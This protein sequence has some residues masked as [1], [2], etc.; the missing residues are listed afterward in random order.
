MAR[1]KADAAAGGAAERRAEDVEEGLVRAA[2]FCGR[3]P[4]AY[5]RRG[6]PAAYALL[7]AALAGRALAAGPTLQLVPDVV[8]KACGNPLVATME[9]PA[10][11]SCQDGEVHLVLG[12][13]DP[14]LLDSLT[15]TI[16]STSP[17]RGTPTSSLREALVRKVS[18]QNVISV[19]PKGKAS[20]RTTVY[21][22]VIDTKGQFIQAD[23]AVV[24]QALTPVFDDA[25]P[26]RFGPICA[27][28]ARCC[29]GSPCVLQL[30]MPRDRA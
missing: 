15:V 1:E 18:G 3:R 8:I 9:C 12:H 26:T 29:R 22:K 16:E 13:S 19:C 28:P 27:C 5:R 10:A 17:I 11:S 30:C 23:F 25:G 4:P 24:V 20:G 14:T 2:R 7:A 21:I 6:L